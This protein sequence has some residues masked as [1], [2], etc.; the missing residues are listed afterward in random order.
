MSRTA[1]SSRV[2]SAARFSSMAPSSDRVISRRLVAFWFLLSGTGLLACLSNIAFAYDIEPKRPLSAAQELKVAHI[3]GGVTVS[4]ETFAYTFQSAN[5]LV[6]SVKV[7][8]REL[9]AAP[10]PDLMAAEQF[11]P[12]VSPYLA[13]HETHG[14]VKV[15]TSSPDRVVIEGAGAYTAGDGHRLPLRY[16][17]RYE[18][19]I[20]GVMLVSLTNTASAPCT[21]RW[22]RLSAGSVRPELAKFLNWMPEQSTSQTTGYQFRTLSG[23][24][25]NVLSGTWIPWIW[26]GDQ[27]VG[28]EVTTWDVGSQ[29][30][31]QLDS[32]ARKDEAAMFE[33]ERDGHGTRW[34]N[35]L[36]RRTRVYAGAGWTRSGSFALGVTPTKRFDPYYALIKDAHLGP[37]QHVADLKALTEEQIRT[38]AANGYNLVVGIANWRSG[39]YVALNEAD[40]RRTIA[41]CH[42]YGLKIIPYMTLVDLSHATETWR[43][44]GEEWAIEPT[45]EYAM[46]MRPFDRAAEFTWRNRDE[47]ETTLM[48][49]GA[50]GWRE[51]WKRQIDRVIRDYDFDGIYFDFWYGRMVCENTRHGCG[52]RF[53]MGTVLGSREM[54]AYASNRLHAKN[55]HAIIKANTNTLAT[56]LI[57]SFADIRVVGE[58]IGMNQMDSDS[59]EWLFSS[60]RLGESTQ[61]LAGNDWT[62]QRKLWFAVLVNFLPNILDQPEFKLRT[63]FDD[64]DVFRSFDDGTG[65]WTLGISGKSPLKAKQDEVS[66]NVVERG[67]EMLATLVA[68][69]KRAITAEVPVGQGSR[70]AFEP[71]AGRAIAVVNGT[72]ALDLAPET[73]RHVLIVPPPAGPKLLWALGARRPAHSR[74]DPASRKLSISADTAEGAA[75][76]LAIFSRFAPTSVVT[77]HGEKLPFDYK[78]ESSFVLVNLKPAPGERIEVSL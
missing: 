12:A 10:I 55:P 34:E 25:G 67:D 31:G 66:V 68:T 16:S 77:T 73:Y 21:L 74:Y 50:K 39:E 30:Y 52:G 69:G 5:G 42:K 23:A 8:G 6:G 22:L 60:V 49:P 1:R 63:R 58:D 2:A 19:S 33:V 61:L 11:D 70:L 54:L 24:E 40:L 78:A 28:L 56:A 17:L 46:G 4:G 75:L 15:V 9:L 29:T 47:A 65:K 51:H 59:R 48:C 71:L 7:L 14:T 3:A 44:H 43:Q 37:H 72:L 57:T 62:P 41:L 64:F 45:T 26:I 38:L 13:R 32:T 20:D 35:W 36:I 53:R 76:Q 27:N 18:I